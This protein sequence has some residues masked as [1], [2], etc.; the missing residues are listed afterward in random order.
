MHTHILTPC[1]FSAMPLKKKYFP[2]VRNRYLPTSVC[3]V[4][5]DTDIAWSMQFPSAGVSTADRR[6]RHFCTGLWHEGV[7]RSGSDGGG[8]GE[9]QRLSSGI[10][11]TTVPEGVKRGTGGGWGCR[12]I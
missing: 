7:V 6:A 5:T 4:P 10:V 2:N 3:V 11:P 1:T 9:I 12:I 8:D